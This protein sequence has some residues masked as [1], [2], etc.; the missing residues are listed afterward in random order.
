MALTASLQVVGNVI[1]NRPSTCVLTVSNS[2][3]DAVNVTSIQ[4]TVS[5]SGGPFV[6]GPI[7]VSP[8]QALASTSGM[9]QQ[10]AVPG[11]GSV[12]FP[13]S[14][15]AYSG[16]VE[17]GLPQQPSLAWTLGANCTGSDGSVF[18]PQPQFV[19]IAQPQFGQPPGSPPN[20][21]SSRGEL[22]FNLGSN[23]AF[24]L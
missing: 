16:S 23:S 17:T 20:V 14:V 2:G 1:A 3:V 11:G 7:T 10:V 18:S 4:P 6:I 22:Q 21:S 19:A 13:F 5:P 15:V 9:Q 12:S 8:A 24:F